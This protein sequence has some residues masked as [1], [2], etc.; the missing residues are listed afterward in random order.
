MTAARDAEDVWVVED[1]RAL[2]SGVVALLREQGLKTA[3]YGD[4]Q[5]ALA[6]AMKCP[7][8]L[9]IVDVATPG[10]SGVEL[11]RALRLALGPSCPRILLV[12]ASEVRRVD[13]TLF[14][15]VVRKPYQFQELLA[16]VLDYLA[17]RERGTGRTRRVT[18]GDRA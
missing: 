12:T 1:D 15:H 4:P 16:K 5:R 17:P 14:D 6:E 8:R 7:P 11:A 13:L 10:M 2:L 18:R 3:G 9:M